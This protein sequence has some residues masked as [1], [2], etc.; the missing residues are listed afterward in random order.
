MTLANWVTLSRLAMAP[1][2]FWAWLIPGKWFI[3]TVALIFTGLTDLLDG[4]LARKRNEISDLGKILDPV[5]DKAVFAGVLAALT[6]R[7]FIP[8]F[9][10]WIYLA[11]EIVQLFGGA[12]ILTRFHRVVPS[13][14]W[15]KS[16]SVIFYL[17]IFAVFLHREVGFVIICTGLVLSIIALIT[18]TKASVSQKP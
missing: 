8:S 16:S 17:G 6:L 5:A 11:K 13:N 7:G 14:M 18:Y 10:V 12:F 1:F 4:A 2:I 15:G 3:G 9:L